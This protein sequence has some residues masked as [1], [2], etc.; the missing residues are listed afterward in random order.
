MAQAARKQAREQARE[1][2]LPTSMAT[3]SFVEVIDADREAFLQK[4]A[5]FTHD[6]RV[7]RGRP[8]GWEPPCAK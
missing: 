1:Q 7:K 4:V 6:L 5:K 3:E 2:S 8:C